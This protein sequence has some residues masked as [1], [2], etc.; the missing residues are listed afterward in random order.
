MQFSCIRNS[1]QL[2]LK[3]AHSTDSSEYEVS[4]GLECINPKHHRRQSDI[5]LIFS[6]IDEEFYLFS[7]TLYRHAK[8]KLDGTVSC[9]YFGCTTCHDT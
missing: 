1:A 5:I 4:K 3:L 6:K 9:A 2:S 8:Q 7:M